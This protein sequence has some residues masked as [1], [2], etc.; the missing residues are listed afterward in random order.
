MVTSKES[1]MV[2][3]K[4]GTKDLLRVLKTTSTA[5]HILVKAYLSG[6]SNIL[7]SRKRCLYVDVRSIHSRQHG[8]ILRDQQ[9]DELKE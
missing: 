3:Q 4:H 8:R 6:T 7:Q 2:R 1:Q 5:A 9:M